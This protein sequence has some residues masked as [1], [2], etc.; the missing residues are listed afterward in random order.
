[1]TEVPK[2]DWQTK[3]IIILIAGRAGTGK[4]TTANLIKKNL[5]ECYS[6]FSVISSFASMV[7]AVA[8]FM[9]WNGEKDTKGRKLLQGIGNLGRE[10]DNDAWIELLIKGIEDTFITPLDFIIIDDWRFPNEGK[11]FIKHSDE[12]DIYTIRIY[13]PSREILKNTPEYNDVSETSLS[14]DSREY[15]WWVNNEGTMEELEEKV[16]MII[17]QILE[18]ETEESDV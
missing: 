7:K 5:P 6:K 18:I 11:W 9:G 8:K 12:Y 15:D 3:T 10:Y 2:L 17:D 13:A 4:T 1:M 14:E 16:K